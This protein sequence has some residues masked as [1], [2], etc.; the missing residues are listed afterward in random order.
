V[1]WKTPD[2]VDYGFVAPAAYAITDIICHRKA[3]NALLAAPARAGAKIE[4][5]WDT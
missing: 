1:G 2:A 4:I 3:T 5:L